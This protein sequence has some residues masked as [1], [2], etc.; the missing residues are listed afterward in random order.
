MTKRLE[1]NWDNVER[2]YPNYYNCD[3]IGINSRL[4]CIVENGEEIPDDLTA[5][6]ITPENANVQYDESYQFIEMQT[7]DSMLIALRNAIFEGKVKVDDIARMI[8]N[9][10]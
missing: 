6:G 2:F 5:I 3:V 9:D 7:V 8:P 4:S 1:M 10:G